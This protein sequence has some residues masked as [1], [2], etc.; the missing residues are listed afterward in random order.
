MKLVYWND[1]KDMQNTA[2]RFHRLESIDNLLEPFG[3]MIVSPG[4]W[5]ALL[6]I[7]I[8]FESVSFRCFIS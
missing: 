1:E 4:G 2:D 8:S 6:W 5:R 7:H 3:F